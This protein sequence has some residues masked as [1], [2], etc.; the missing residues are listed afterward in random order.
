MMSVKEILPIRL[1]VDSANRQ[2]AN[3]CLVLPS[4]QVMRLGDRSRINLMPLE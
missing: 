4:C 3:P 2:V 1:K